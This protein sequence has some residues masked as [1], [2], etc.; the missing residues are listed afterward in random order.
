MSRTTLQAAW[1]VC[2]KCRVVNISQPAQPMAAIVNVDMYLTT[3]PME[4]NMLDF[5]PFRSLHLLP[6]CLALP[7][8]RLQ[9]LLHHH[10]W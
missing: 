2:V 7:H 4:E 3:A 5:A 8:I 6:Y 1:Y 9:I 10:F